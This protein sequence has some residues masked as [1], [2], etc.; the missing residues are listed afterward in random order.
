MCNKMPRE[1]RDREGNKRKKGLKMALDS[2]LRNHEIGITISPTS[3]ADGHN[4]RRLDIGGNQPPQDHQPRRRDEQAQEHQ[5]AQ[6]QQRVQNPP[7]DNEEGNPQG[8]DAPHRTPTPPTII[9]DAQ[10]V[11]GDD[12][13]VVRGN[14][15][16]RVAAGANHAGGLP[17]LPY[18]Q[19]HQDPEPLVSP[20]L[21]ECKHLLSTLQ[22][23][24]I[25]RFSEANE[26]GID[27]EIKAY[28]LVCARDL[29]EIRLLL[30]TTISS[31]ERF[32]E[33][34]IE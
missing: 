27:P 3:S 5:L 13:R 17:Q 26:R 7:R 4:R 21:E 1:E 22:D 6:N 9:N 30:G 15:Q 28:L 11:R 31:L 20:I 12:Q 14:Y 8:D 18:R 34:S 2:L 25:D 29:R 32:P 33:W 10:E 24:C 19:G 23:R 16:Q